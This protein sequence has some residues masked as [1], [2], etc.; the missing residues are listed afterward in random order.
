MIIF[1]IL[2]IQWE[3]R[4]LLIT[5]NLTKPSDL[6]SLWVNLKD[7]ILLPIK[8]NER[9]N[10]VNKKKYLLQI[11]EYSIKTYNVNKIN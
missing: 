8:R 3:Q 9:K 5:R 1:K 7:V 4:S 6:L 2:K 11:I 10:V